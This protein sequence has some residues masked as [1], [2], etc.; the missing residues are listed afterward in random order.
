M[1][2]DLLILGGLI[3][4]DWST[5]ERMPF[6]GKQAMAVHKLPGGARVID[7]LGPDERDITWTGTFWGSGAYESALALNGLRQSGQVVPLSFAGQSYR[8]LVA[9]ALVDIRRLPQ[10]ATYTVNCIVATNPMAGNLSS[11]ASTVDTTV[12]ADIATSGAI[13]NAATTGSNAGFSVGGA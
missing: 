10:Y 11:Q 2:T 4:D 13:A 6:G 1:A 12:S 3:F 7:T 8:V 9:E 5:P